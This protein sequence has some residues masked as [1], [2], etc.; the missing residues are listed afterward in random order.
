MT[1]VNTQH[2]HDGS[3]H[4]EGGGLTGATID[5]DYFY[6]FCPRCP[7]QQILRILEYSLRDASSEHPYNSEYKVKAKNGFTLEF[8]AYCEQCKKSDIFKVSN[9][10]LQGVS[11]YDASKRLG[12]I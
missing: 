6:F 4:V 9:M 3:G 11:R 1:T 12:T 2:P 7:D 5:T 10:G 8:K